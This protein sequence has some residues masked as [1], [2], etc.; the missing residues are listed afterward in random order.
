MDTTST[1]SITSSRR[2]IELIRLLL[3]WPETTVGYLYYKSDKPSR[4][5]GTELIVPV[6]SEANPFISSVVAR[7][8]GSEDNDDVLSVVP[9]DKDLYLAITPTVTYR[10]KTFAITVPTTVLTGSNRDISVALVSD[11]YTNNQ[12][13]SAALH[14][15]NNQVAL[16]ALAPPILY[17]S[18]VSTAAEVGTG[19]RP[20]PDWNHSV[21]ITPILPTDLG[22]LSQFLV[23][24]GPPWGR[25]HQ[26]S[27]GDYQQSSTLI[28]AEVLRALVVQL[29]CQLDQLHQL[30]GFR[31]GGLVASSITVQNIPLE[32]EYRGV[33]M[34]SPLTCHIADVSR[35]SLTLATDGR[36]LTIGWN[37][38]LAK[39]KSFRI[40]DEVPDGKYVVDYRN[41]S[42][43][44]SWD[45]YTL[46]T[47][48]LLIPSVHYRWFSD[49][50]LIRDLWLPLWR[51]QKQAEDV[52]RVLHAAIK[53]SR[54]TTVETV[55]CL[56][57]PY[58]LKEDVVQ[59]QLEQWMP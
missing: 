4:I 41:S 35:A 5:E 22:S 36:R 14:Y 50:D 32:S 26:I 16:L 40:A 39:I 34:V 44:R 1:S 15:L 58:L 51:D 47:S 9:L 20:A 48:M 59:L 29:T 27:V 17:A 31:G 30:V 52:Q 23:E 6:L 57:Q 54:P 2:N 25:L 13:I 11:L 53:D 3:Q 56:L 8:T 45:Y 12:L 18:M 49:T 28:D 19:Q 24:L 55:A 10:V 42:K 46:L 38:Q 43:Y 7:I 33:N 37:D 21:Q